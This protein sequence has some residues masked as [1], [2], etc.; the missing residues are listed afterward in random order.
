MAT[1]T[2]KHTKNEIWRFAE[3]MVSGGA[4]FWS[5]YIL[6]VLLDNH[7]G[8]F[9]ANLVGNA[10]GIT[11]NFLLQRYWV[12]SKNKDSAQLGASAKRYVVYTV[13][14]AFLLNYLILLGLQ[15]VGIKPEFGQFIAAGFFTGWNYFWYKVYIFPEKFGG[16]TKP[17]KHGPFR[18]FAHPSHGHQ[19]YRHSK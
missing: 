19:A 11:I 8:L 15:N 14:N 12:F 10:V 5:G 18:I 13:L 7:I 16:Q 6:I 2:K 9:L 4:W 1:K 3:Y 17:V